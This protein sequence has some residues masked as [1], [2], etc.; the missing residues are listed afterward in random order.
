MVKMARS[1]GNS[2]LLS[3]NFSWPWQWR[4][5]KDNQGLKIVYFELNQEM[6]TRKKLIFIYI[7]LVK[8]IYI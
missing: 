1:R 7:N 6:T 8:N 4:L 2:P 5:F 3:S